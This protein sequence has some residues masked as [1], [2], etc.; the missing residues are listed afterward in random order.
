LTEKIRKIE[1]K[2][3]LL[4]FGFD[5]HDRPHI[6]VITEY[7][8]IQWCD[9]EGVAA[10]GSGAWVF[11]TALA[12]YG[13]NRHAERGEAVWAML[14]SKFAAEKAEGVGEQTVLLIS[15]ATDRLGYTVS[16][17]L[18]KDINDAR[19]RWRSLARIPDGIARELEVKISK[20]EQDGSFEVSNP[21]RGYLR[22]SVARKAKRE[23]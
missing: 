9:A 19:E 3:N 22:Q 14:S 5:K 18:P 11:W 6:F 2:W 4:F 1:Q 13:Y 20:E 23:R 16:G 12:Q 17:L 8:K 21:L 15:K 7:G 10:I